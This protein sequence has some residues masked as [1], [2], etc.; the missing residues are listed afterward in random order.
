MMNFQGQGAEVC[1]VSLGSSQFFIPEVGHEEGGC[2]VVGGGHC[3]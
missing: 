3:S 2:A 1:R